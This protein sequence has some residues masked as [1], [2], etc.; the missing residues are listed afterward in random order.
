[1]LL[2]AALAPGIARADS[3]PDTTTVTPDPPPDT[4]VAASAPAPPEGAPEGWFP[5]HRAVPNEP[6]WLIHDWSLRRL[7]GERQAHGLCQ[8]HAA[9]LQSALDICRDQRL[10]DVQ[11]MQSGDVGWPV[12]AHASIYAAVT[13]LTAVATKVWGDDIADALP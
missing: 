8:E 7:V 6:T 4:A 2:L 3:P 1:M 11:R 12:W 13:L 9:V 10:E 5:P